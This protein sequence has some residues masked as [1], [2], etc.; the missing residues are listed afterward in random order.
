MTKHLSV[1]ELIEKLKSY[2][3]DAF[4]CINIDNCMIAVVDVEGN[5][6]GSWCEGESEVRV[7][8]YGSEYAAKSDM[9]QVFFDS[10]A[11]KQGKGA[12]DEMRDKLEGGEGEEWKKN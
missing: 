8:H 1:G 11:L 4:L 5:Q 6:E 2:P 9:V 3:S 10:D 12:I 7:D